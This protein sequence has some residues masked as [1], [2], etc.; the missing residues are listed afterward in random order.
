MASGGWLEPWTR[1]V[2]H[3][4]IDWLAV[5][6]G[7]SWLDIGCGEGILS[8]VILDYARPRAVK[9][10]DAD[11]ENV[12]AAA[13]F[14]GSQR[15]DFDVCDPRAL[16]VRSAS[17]DAAVAGLLLHDTAEPE[18]VVAEMVRVVHAGGTVGALVW[19]YGRGCEPVDAFW[20]A[21]TALGLPDAREADERARYA[22]A[23]PRA[24]RG[25]F[26]QAGL[27]DVETRAIT[28]AVVFADFQDYWERFRGG[29]EPAQRFVNGLDVDSREQ[30]RINLRGTLPRAAEGAI[31]MTLKAWAIRGVREG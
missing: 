25:L 12:G 31:P 14:I 19:A 29:G 2:A 21:A 26:D 20:A 18:Q 28:V 17:V 24:L 9:G 5:D 15:A 16:C 10:I 4:F 11:E 13:H 22:L 27:N 23:R 7:A 3:Q 6:Q 1:L 30:L 8:R